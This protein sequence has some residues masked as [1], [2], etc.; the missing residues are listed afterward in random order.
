[1]VCVVVAVAVIVVCVL[2]FVLS[3]CSFGNKKPTVTN[4]PTTKATVATLKSRQPN[5]SMWRKPQNSLTQRSTPSRKPQN[6][7][8]Q[9]STP[10]G[11]RA[12]HRRIYRTRNLRTCPGYRTCNGV[13]SRRNNT[14]CIKWRCKKY[15]M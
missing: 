7:L 3:K 1:M 14:N 6:S 15:G 9:R 8:T 10:A 13:C 12:L 2:A 5:R 11:N 4:A